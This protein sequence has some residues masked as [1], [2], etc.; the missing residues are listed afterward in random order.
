MKKT[1]LSIVIASTLTAGATLV[2]T[3]AQ[4]EV[5]GNIGVSNNYLWRGV[6]QTEDQAAISGGLDYSHASGFYAGTWASNINW[7]DETSDD[8][9]YELDLYAGFGG[10][11]GA[12]GY[13]LGVI[14]YAY[15]LHEDA[16]FTEA[17]LSGSYSVFSAGLAY[18]FNSDLAEDECSVFCEGDLYYH[19]GLDFEVA[20]DTGLSFLVGSYEFD[21]S[22]E[23]DYTHYAVSLSKGDFAVGL[24]QNDIDGDDDVRFLVSWGKAFTF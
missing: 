18:T 9:G 23:D 17:Y 22:D 2:P 6:T 14:H 24:E 11:V 7:G 4:A 10:E 12:L 1:A 19:A 8:T 5:T 16:D 3:A 15:P 13:D 21:N 20:E